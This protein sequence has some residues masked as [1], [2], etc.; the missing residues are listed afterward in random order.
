METSEAIPSGAIDA[1]DLA[2]LVRHEG[3]FL[4]LYLTIEPEVENAAQRTDIRWRALRSD[5]EGRDVPES[6]LHEIDALV[7]DA[8]VHGEGIGI[9]GT[10]EGVLRVAYGAG[11]PGDD[12]ATWGPI[13]RV[14][15]M[16]ASRQ[17]HP[18]HVVVLT[19]R[20]G[21]NVYAFRYGAP[22][23]EHEV[24]GDH[25]VISKVSP[26]GWSQ[27]RF[28]ERAEDSWEQ[29]AAKVASAVAT[30]VDRVGARLTV[31]GG[32]VRAVQLLRDSLPAEID[33]TVVV[34]D[35]ERPWDDTADTL[36]SE[37]EDLVRDVVHSETDALLAK[38][39]E[40]RGQ[41]DLAVEG[42]AATA[43]ALAKAQVAALLVA[44]DRDD[45][46]TLWFGPADPAL[47]ATSPEDLRALGVDDP[48]EAPAR[49]VLV[50]AALGTGAG[51]RVLD[52]TPRVS[53]GEVELGDEAPPSPEVSGPAAPREGVGG[54]LRWAS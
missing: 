3:P 29:N 23:V 18:T 37:L 5:L 4:S 36:P 52:P 20:T 33:R 32:D 24:E 22:D 34:V 31:L 8:H 39:A 42:A 47:L 50:R 2:D 14:L 12:E 43:R 51:V 53:A 44:D 15:P 6:L 7:P 21:A 46:H 38:L 16:I 19:D 26:G 10:P 30:V 54:L 11:P 45:Q 35:G 17:R 49:D 28:Q 48:K 27:R 25:N 41:S 40:E 9:I 13:P 1:S